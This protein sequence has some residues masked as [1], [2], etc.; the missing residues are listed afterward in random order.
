M[1]DFFINIW[2]LVGIAYLL[3]LPLAFRT[4][5]AFWFFRDKDKTAKRAMKHG[6]FIGLMSIWFVYP[7][8]LIKDAFSSINKN[9]QQ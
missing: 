3:A 9:K 1:K 6:F 8:Y 4:A 5:V 7:I 2:V